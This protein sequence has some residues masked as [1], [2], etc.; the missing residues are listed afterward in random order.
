MGYMFAT[1]AC[2]G[3]GALFCYN[4]ERVPSVV[5]RGSKEPICASCVE[6]VNPK[7]VA[8][9]LEPIRPLPGAYDSQEVA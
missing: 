9:G 6:R 2:I 4:P 3:C 7:R 5:I 1:S 8:N